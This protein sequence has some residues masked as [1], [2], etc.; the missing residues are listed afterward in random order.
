VTA[1]VHDHDLV[2]TIVRFHD[3]A[4]L[5]ELGRA[6]LSLV[7]QT[8]RPLRV[9][10]V[11]QRFDVAALAAVEARLELYRRLDPTVA[12]EVVPY[13]RTSGLA[14]AKAALMNIGIAAGRGRYLAAL[15]YDDTLYPRAYAVL[16]HE[17]LASGCAVALAGV[18]RTSLAVDPGLRLGLAFA[19]RPRPPCDSLI[20]LFRGPCSPAHGLLLDRSRIAPAD[21]LMDETLA[22]TES[23]ERQ[24]RLATCYPFSFAC[25]GETVGEYCL[26]DDGSN[27]VLLAS[28]MDVARQ[29]S[30]A[31]WSAEM[32]RRRAVLPIAIAVQRAIGV[33][34][35]RP[36]LTVRGLLDLLDRGELVLRP[37]DH[38]APRVPVMLPWDVAY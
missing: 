20:D 12:L 11:T 34:S 8:Y 9:M 14:D 36:G 32:E 2:E 16:V 37:E 22:G 4:R 35:P 6:L 38:L 27:S 5:D 21:L 3:P 19:R 33:P 17:L 10:V 15:D 31:R 7:G 29:S 1:E 30:R 28:N 25:L 13:T 18:V 26:K 23:Y 24:L